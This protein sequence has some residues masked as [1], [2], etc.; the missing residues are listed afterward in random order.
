LTTPN[1]EVKIIVKQNTKHEPRGVKKMYCP[2]CEIM[3]KTFSKTKNGRTNYRCPKCHKIFNQLYETRFK[4]TKLNNEQIC[5]LKAYLESGLSPT[6]IKGFTG[7]SRP[8]IYR[9]KRIFE[10]QQRKE[11]RN[12]A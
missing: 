3:M 11:T 10:A 12:A 8:T 9:F 7:I 5:T 1:S 6:T 4:W 2:D